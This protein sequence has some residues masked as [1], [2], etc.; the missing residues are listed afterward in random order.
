MHG[1][2]TLTIDIDVHVRTRMRLITL[3]AVNTPRYTGVEVGLYVM[4][5]GRGQLQLTP[6]TRQATP[7][8]QG[9]VAEGAIKCEM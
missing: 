1:F 7:Q 3:G 2:V 8:P 5:S 9:T 4:S 6:Q